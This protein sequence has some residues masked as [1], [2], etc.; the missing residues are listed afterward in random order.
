MLAG[1]L[2]QPLGWSGMFLTYSVPGFL[3]AGWF[4]WW[5]RNHPAEHSGV[6]NAELAVIADGQELPALRPASENAVGRESPRSTAIAAHREAA[7]GVPSFAALPAPD[8]RQRVSVL[9]ALLSVPLILLFSQQCCRAG[10]LRLFETRLP[11]Y[12]EEERLEGEREIR[13]KQAAKLASYPQWAGIFGSVL[14][15]A[16][17]DFVLRRTGNRRLARNGIAI[18]SLASATAIYLGAWFV[19]D[20]TL[21]ILVLSAGAFFFSFSSPCAYALCI[22]I[23]GKNLAVIFGLMNMLGNLGAFAFVSSIM[24]LVAHGGWELA[25]GFWLALHVIALVCWLFLDPNVVIGEAVPV[26]LAE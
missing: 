20:V 18:F 24:T 16:L 22:D 8:V 3:W 7:S 25:L 14:G 15:G 11:T 9:T 1:E 12:L 5:F 6:N 17:S 21:A 23:G 10:A 26:R 4:F 13:R 2:L 19:A